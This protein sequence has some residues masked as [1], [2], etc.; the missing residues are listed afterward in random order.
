MDR[1]W[2]DNRLCSRM[3]GGVQNKRDDGR[4]LKTILS[5]WH[6]ASASSPSQGASECRCAPRAMTKKTAAPW[7]GEGLGARADFGESLG[8]VYRPMSNFIVATL[9]FDGGR[10]R[11]ERGLIRA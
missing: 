8:L 3:T 9:E 5:R 6:R 11:E 7:S 2:R 10:G 1:S 4:E